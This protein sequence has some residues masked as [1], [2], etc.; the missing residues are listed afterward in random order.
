MKPY[1]LKIGGR[2]WKTV[3]AV[4]LCLCID[5]VRVGGVPFYAAIAAILCVQRNQ[6]DSFQVAMNREISTVIGGIF[7]MLFLAFEREY[8]KKS[9]N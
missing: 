1:S 5:A 6:K 8:E 9:V 3:I 2:I 7:G 4:F